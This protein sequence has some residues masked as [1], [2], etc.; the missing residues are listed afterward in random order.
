MKKLSLKN[1]ASGQKGLRALLPAT[2]A[3]KTSLAMTLT[4][5]CL[6]LLTA[7]AQGTGFF[8]TS[9]YTKL[10]VL[11]GVFCVIAGLFF[12]LKASGRLNENHAVYLLVLAGVFLRC[13]YV[14]LSG[15][16]ELPV[17]SSTPTP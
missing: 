10:L 6:C 5:I 11:V 9:H 4:V 13:G 3:E 14:L 2:P 8:Y 17:E 15:L 1:T 7:L 16:Y 12:H